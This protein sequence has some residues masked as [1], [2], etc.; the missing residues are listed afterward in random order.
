[1]FESGV[2][3]GPWEQQALTA[4][5]AL[6]T[7]AG[8]YALQRVG[9]Y[10]AKKGI[11]VNQN[12]WDIALQNAIAYGVQVSKSVI[13]AKGWDHMDTHNAIVNAALTYIVTHNADILSAVGLTTNLSDPSNQNKIAEALSRAVPQ[14]VGALANSAATP[15]ATLTVAAIAAGKPTSL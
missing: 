13:T 7:A 8:T 10:F 3:L 15:P 9:A 2:D 11:M 14:V 1:M 6:A 5:A 12:L 4:I